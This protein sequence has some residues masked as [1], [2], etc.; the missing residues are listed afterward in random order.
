MAVQFKYLI[1]HTFLG[2]LL[3]MEWHFS[4]GSL[5]SH[6]NIVQMGTKFAN[7]LLYRAPDN[8][9]LVLDSNGRV[10]VAIPQ[11]QRNMHILFTLLAFLFL[12]CISSDLFSK[13]CL[14]YQG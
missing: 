11:S 5:A 2:L 7:R 10:I 12:F 8:Q 13:L 6:Q 4:C 1:Q 14:N 3:C 9:M